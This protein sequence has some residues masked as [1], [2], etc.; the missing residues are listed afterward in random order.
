MF[1]KSLLTVVARQTRQFVRKKIK[2]VAFINT[3]PSTNTIQLYW[4]YVMGE[5]ARGQTNADV[6][7][8]DSKKTTFVIRV[9]TATN[10]TA[11]NAIQLRA[12]RRNRGPI[13]RRRISHRGT[14]NGFY[15]R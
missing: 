15:I 8:K 13:E 10:H 14:N 12:R 4:P 7:T 5:G 6:T 9:I 2:G 1:T 11:S 3:L